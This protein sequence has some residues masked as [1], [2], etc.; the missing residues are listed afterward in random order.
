MKEKQKF[1]VVDK[2][3]FWYS[4]LEP[5]Y[6]MIF[7]SGIIKSPANKDLC[8]EL[9]SNET[10]Q[11]LELFEKQIELIEP[12]PTMDNNMLNGIY[13]KPLPPEVHERF[14]QAIEH[15]NVMPLY[16]VWDP[17]YKSYN[18]DLRVSPKGIISTADGDELSLSNESQAGKN[19]LFSKRK[20]NTFCIV[21]KCTQR[22]DKN[23][24]YIYEGDIVNIEFDDNES[25]QGAVYINTVKTGIRYEP[26]KVVWENGEFHYLF[27]EFHKTPIH[28]FEDKLVEVVANVHTIS[29]LFKTEV[30]PKDFAPL[31]IRQV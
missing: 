19:F 14:K 22:Q 11:I 26:A 18:D 12:V 17:N 1:K 15:G 7:G 20:Y 2:V 29:E 27:A 25:F 16:R 3:K 28:S 9:I 8:Y 6:K 10:N 30:N 24:N 5:T 4:I 13:I 31:P 21:E 23:K